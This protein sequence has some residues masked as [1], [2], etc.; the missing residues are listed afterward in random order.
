MKKGFKIILLSIFLS[1]TLLLSSCISSSGRGVFMMSI[2]NQT[3]TSFKTEY[4][5]FE[6]Y[7]QYKIDFKEGM[8]LSFSFETISGTLGCKISDNKGNVLFD[9]ENVGTM[10]ETITIPSNGK[11]IIYLYA[12]E[13]RGSYSFSWK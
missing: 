13:H 7:K 5:K 1:T 2:S 3:N 6:G 10:S 9:M 12:N 4:H 11:Y 8:V